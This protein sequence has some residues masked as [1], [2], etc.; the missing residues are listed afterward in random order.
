MPH[1]MILNYTSPS[2]HNG[3]VLT[4]PTLAD[5]ETAIR[6]ICK[7][8]FVYV[9]A[10]V[11]VRVHACVC[12]C[13]HAWVCVVGLW[14]FPQGQSTHTFC[15]DTITSAVIKVDAYENMSSV[16]FH[17]ITEIKEVD[18]KEFIYSTIFKVDNVLQWKPF[19]FSLLVSNTVGDSPFADYF[20]VKGAENGNELKC[21]LYITFMY[22]HCM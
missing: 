5:K 6:K 4:L 14:Y 18:S 17:N 3:F 10:C 22:S 9:C 21:H 19:N 7:F 2:F 12:A 1:M 8:N 11:C 13:V 15:D 16:I 20:H